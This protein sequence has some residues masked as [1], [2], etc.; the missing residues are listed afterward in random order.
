MGAKLKQLWILFPVGM[1]WFCTWLWH[2]A[3]VDR[4]A[5]YHFPFAF[6]L[7]CAVSYA[8]VFGLYKLLK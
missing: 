6:T 7:W 1:L 8:A 5:W 3:G 4:D 2:I